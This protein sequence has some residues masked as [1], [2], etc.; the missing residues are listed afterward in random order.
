MRK[1]QDRLNELSKLWDEMLRLSIQ[2]NQSLQKEGITG[3]ELAKSTDTT[4]KHSQRD[5][6]KGKKRYYNEFNSLAMQWANSAGTEQGDI[7]RLFD[8][9]NRKW[10]LAIADENS[11]GGYRILK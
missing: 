3:E 6:E 4:V 2:A 10:A 9:K 1:Y 11:D 7:K 8:G 5:V